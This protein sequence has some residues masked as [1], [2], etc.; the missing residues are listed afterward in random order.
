MA[1][2][3]RKWKEDMDKYPSETKEED[4]DIYQ[5]IEDES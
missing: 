3:K 5:F 4:M 2:Y 1:R